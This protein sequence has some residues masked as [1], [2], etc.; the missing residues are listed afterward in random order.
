MNLL[1]TD[2][3]T[4]VAYVPTLSDAQKWYEI[5]DKFIFVQELLDLS[6]IDDGDA[7]VNRRVDRVEIA[8]ERL[9][10]EVWE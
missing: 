8:F 7:Y 6:L 10:E 2:R 5:T 9:L 3:T 1:Q 4:E